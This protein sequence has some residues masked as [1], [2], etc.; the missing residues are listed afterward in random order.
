MRFPPALNPLRKTRF[1]WLVPFSWNLMEAAARAAP[2]TLEV[3]LHHHFGVRTVGML[4]KGFL[5]LV[6]ICFLSLITDP[7]PAFALF[8]GYVLG[9]AIIATGHWLT[10]RLHRDR[11]HVHSYLCGEPWPVWQVL[12][13]AGTTVKRYVEPL[14]CFIFSFLVAPLDSGFAHWVRLAAMALFVK[15]QIIRVCLRT[16]QL[17]TMDNRAEAHE[18]APRPRQERNTFVEARPAPTPPRRPPQQRVQTPRVIIVRQR[19]GTPRR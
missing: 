13:L 11:E 5:L 1:A 3:F 4:L 15:E 2:I 9:Y 18:A 8:P 17:D 7:R 12:P 19:P 16:R 10:S 14:L 6:I